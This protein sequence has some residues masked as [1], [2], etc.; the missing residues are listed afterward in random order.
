M[1]LVYKTSKIFIRF[2]IRNFTFKKAFTLKVCDK[3]FLLFSKEI[4]FFETR[5]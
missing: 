2:S 1:L 5:K 4:E 3:L